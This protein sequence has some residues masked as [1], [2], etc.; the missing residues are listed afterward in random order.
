[1]S[2]RPTTLARGAQRARERPRGAVRTCPSIAEH[3]E[4]RP[5]TFKRFRELTALLT[6][7]ERERAFFNV[8]RPERREEAWANLESDA[9]ARWEVR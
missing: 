9:R 4:R 8:L 5:L 1:M 3:S 2:T 7:P 6:G